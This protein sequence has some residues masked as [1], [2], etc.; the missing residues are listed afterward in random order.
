MKNY[1]R[2]KIEKMS[3]RKYL[4]QLFGN[5]KIIIQVLVNEKKVEIDELISYGLDKKAKSYYKY[6]VRNNEELSENVIIETL[7]PFYNYKQE[8][9]DFC[10]APIDID[11]DSQ[12]VLNMWSVIYD[13]SKAHENFKEGMHFEYY[14]SKGKGDFGNFGGPLELEFIREWHIANDHEIPKY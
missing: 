12:N 10:F 4:K 1:K 7:Y 13:L 6:L 5:Q 14:M 2:I 9:R 11:S 3:D 8:E